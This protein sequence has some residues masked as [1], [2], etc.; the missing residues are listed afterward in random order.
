M[1]YVDMEI[2]GISRT[3]NNKRSIKSSF[4]REKR[5][6]INDY[7]CDKLRESGYE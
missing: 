4:K 7:E 3:K 1:I 5:E 2:N 6:K